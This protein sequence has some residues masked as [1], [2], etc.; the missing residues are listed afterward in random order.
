MILTVNFQIDHF[1]VV[2]YVGF[3]VKDLKSV[4]FFYTK[5]SHSIKNYVH[6]E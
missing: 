2:T 6:H 1:L 5:I 4:Y 3:I